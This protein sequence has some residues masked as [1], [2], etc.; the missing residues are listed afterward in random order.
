MEEYSAWIQSEVSAFNNLKYKKIER[1]PVNENEILITDVYT[2]PIN[3]N[4]DPKTV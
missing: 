4:I 1:P 3:V 2:V